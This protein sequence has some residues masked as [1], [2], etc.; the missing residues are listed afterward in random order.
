MDSQL[1]DYLITQ[2]ESECVEFKKDN[3]NPDKIG[4]YI[5][6]LANSAALHNVAKAY[7][8][9]GIDD[10]THDIIGTSFKP[11]HHKIGN[12]EFERWLHNRLKPKIVFTIQETTYQNK[13]IVVFEI[14]PAR[15]APVAFNGK[16]FIRIGSSTSSLK[17]FPE[18]ERKL[19]QVLSA[20]CFED[21]IAK[22][23]VTTND[24]LSLLD[25]STFFKLLNLPYDEHTASDEIILSKL[26]EHEIVTLQNNTLNITNLGAI[27]FAKNLNNFQSLL[28]KQVRVIK[29]KGINKLR[30]EFEQEGVKGYAAGFQ[31]LIKFIMDKLP[32]NEIIKEALRHETT[33]YPE[34]AIRELVANALIHQDFTITGT[35]PMI[36]IYDDRIEITNNGKP[37]IDV[38]RLIDYRPISRNEKLAK[39]MRLMRI[40]EERG[41]GIDKVIASIEFYQLP[42]PKFRVEDDYFKA[43]IFAPLSFEYMD[44]QDRIRATYQHACL[45]FIQNDF[46]TNSSL[47]QRFNLGEK[48][49]SK[50]SKIINDTLKEKL[51]KPADPENKSTKHIK[52]TPFFG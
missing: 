37:L 8:I 21:E 43:I 39:L 23:N 52:Y 27:L 25:I 44:K 1:L 42:A 3:A 24:I 5:S 2:G 18:K 6:A 20:F 32:K 36:E 29:Y 48:Q 49:H 45:K 34:I 33:L 22:S 16:E 35:N 41:S 38:L 14:D 31:G 19:W 30:T 7:L 4:E 50:V 11:K 12:E 28:R 46:M 15:N 17:D 26:R 51:I 10:S 9:Y 40:C 47:R 13:H